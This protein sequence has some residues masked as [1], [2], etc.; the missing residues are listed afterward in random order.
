T[1]A[2]LCRPARMRR[3][4]A[5][6]ARVREIAVRQTASISTCSASKAAVTRDAR[7][8]VVGWGG[9][10][11]PAGTGAGPAATVAGAPLE[12][13]VSRCSDCRMRS[14]RRTTP[15]STPNS[16]ANWAWVGMRSPGRSA[17]VLIRSRNASATSRCVL[18]GRC[19][20]FRPATETCSGSTT[21]PYNFSPSLGSSGKGG[22]E[23]TT[24]GDN[25]EQV[26]DQ[27]EQH[28]R[29]NEGLA[30]RETVGDH[31]AKGDRHRSEE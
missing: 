11:G 17:P 18:R 23:S 20:L 13:L 27:L 22:Y 24:S 3:T 7:A 12:T 14:A 26:G 25:S 6:M 29:R 30:T 16:P 2:G 8:T 15:R 10:A 21:K 9:A 1:W 19:D 31:D 28:G 5:R 4:G